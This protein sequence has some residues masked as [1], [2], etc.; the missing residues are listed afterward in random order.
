MY[1]SG[2]KPE[3][4]DRVCINYGIEETVT[5]VSDD[6]RG[7]GFKSMSYT[8]ACHCDLISR[9]QD[10]LNLAAAPAERKPTESWDTE[11]LMFDASGPFWF[12]LHRHPDRV[13]MLEVF[14]GSERVCFADLTTPNIRGIVDGLAK[15]VS[16]PAPLNLA[17]ATLIA[18]KTRATT[19]NGGTWTYCKTQDPNPLRHLWVDQHGFE[20]WTD[21]FGRA[22]P[23]QVYIL[24]LLPDAE[25]DKRQDE[26]GF[27]KP[28]TREE[29]K[30]IGLYGKFRIERTDGQSEPGRKHDG[31]DYFVLDMTHDPFALAAI[32]AY[33]TACEDKFPHLAFDLREKYLNAPSPAREDGVETIQQEPRQSGGSMLSEPSEVRPMRSQEEWQ[34]LHDSIVRRFQNMAHA[35]DAA[36]SNTVPLASGG[37][38]RLPTMQAEMLGRVWKDSLSD[39]NQPCVSG[40]LPD[41]PNE[42]VKATLF[43]AKFGGLPEAKAVEPRQAGGDERE[44]DRLRTLIFGMYHAAGTIESGDELEA[45]RRL[46][47]DRDRL[48]SELQQNREKWQTYEREYILPS[49]DWARE[50]LGLDLQKLVTDNPGKNCNQLLFEWMFAKLSGGGLREAASDFVQSATEH[51]GHLLHDDGMRSYRV[52]KSKF[53]A[54]KRELASLAPQAAEGGQA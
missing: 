34:Q 29:K 1:R 6:G 44:C 39:T 24:A 54:L 27:Q 50:K 5:H 13:P 42:I 20:W 3:I 7:V 31:C 40:G 45:V 51:G 16:D 2:E 49:F 53:D 21:D 48:Q 17:A 41:V 4:G 28:L 43:S 10:V 38:Y 19:S 33:A 47:A 15:Y 8:S 25:Q 35:I 18:G 12:A 22:L 9:K 52:H 32:E 11:P 46:R 23:S 14:N 36:L 37:G 30:R 26:A